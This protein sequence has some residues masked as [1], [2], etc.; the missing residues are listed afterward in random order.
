MT[1][2]RMGSSSESSKG[3]VPLAVAATAV[4]FMDAQVPIFPVFLNPGGDSV[5]RVRQFRCTCRLCSSWVQ[6]PVCL[7]MEI[8]KKALT[9][10]ALMSI[11]GAV[12]GF[13]SAYFSQKKRLVTITTGAVGWLP[14][15]LLQCAPEVHE[16]IK[17]LKARLPA[18]RTDAQSGLARLGRRVSSLCKLYNAVCEA[19]PR[20]IHYTISLQGA[21]LC[22]DI[23]RILSGIYLDAGVHLQRGEVGTAEHYHLVPMDHTLLDVHTSIAGYARNTAETIQHAVKH[24]TLLYVRSSARD[25]HANKHGGGERNQKDYI[26]RRE[27]REQREQ[28]ER[29]EYRKHLEYHR[30]RK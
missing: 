7:G 4:L 6:F 13:N 5:W 24:K 23:L 17:A 22:E 16:S 15:R 21:R 14:E 27:Q 28:R 11:V 25:R 8:C 26:S 10:G 2:I 30:D 20:N 12:V 3:A 18:M 19:D 1:S 29:R 9:A